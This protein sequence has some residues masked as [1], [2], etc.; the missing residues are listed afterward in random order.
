MTLSNLVVG[1]HYL[2]MVYCS[3]QS[4]SC[5]GTSSYASVTGTGF[6]TITNIGSQATGGTKDCLQVF[7]TTATATTG[8]IN[9]AAGS[10]GQVIGFVNVVQLSPGA[11]VQT[12]TG[13][14]GTTS[15]ATAPLS[16]PSAS[17]GELVPV[18]VDDGNGQ[19]TIAAQT[20]SSGMNRLGA[21]QQDGT[22]GADMSV[23]FDSTPQSTSSF[24]LNPT[25]PLGG[26]AT[27]A[28]QFG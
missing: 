26:W 22:V 4:S 11:A 9:V 16:S 20:P 7:D 12:H 15:P 6:G 19:T 25:S 5:N 28:I 23:Y 1:S 14:S 13:K 18:A 2:V 3:G 8:T 24:T 10:S 27:F 17:Y 21:A